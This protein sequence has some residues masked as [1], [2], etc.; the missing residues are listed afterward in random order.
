[1]TLSDDP[2]GA[3]IVV[4][5]I[6]RSPVVDSLIVSGR[7]D[8]SALYDEDGAVRW[9]GFTIAVVDEVLYLVGT[10]RRGT[11]YA[12]YEFARAIGVS[13]WHWW[14]DAPIH[15]RDHVTV[16]SDTRIS[17]WPSVRYR[18]VFINDEEELYH[19]ARQHTADDTIGPETYERVFELLLRLGGNY[20]WPAMHIG[21]FNHDPENGR[22]ANE[23]GIVVGTSH[24]DILLRSNNH[25][26]QPWADARAE[27]VEYDYSLAG[28]NRE[29]LRDY[30]RDSVEQNSDYEVT[31]TLGVR[32]VHDSGFET[33]AIDSDETLDEN[34]K[35]RARVALL[36][37]AIH[38]QRSILSEALGV[39]PDHAPQLFIPYK[40][41]LPLYDAG[42][43]VPDDVTLVW[44]NDNFG[45][46]RRFPS[47]TERA[48]AGG[49]G[50]YYHSS[51]WSNY[52][53]SYLGTSST[54]LSLMRSELTKAWAGGI[55]HLWIDNVGGLKPLEIET[56]FFLRSAWEAGRE[57]STSDIRDF[58]ARWVDDTFSGSLGTRAADIYARYYQLNNQRKYEHLSAEVFAQIGYGDEAGRRLAG[59][60]ALF[61]EANA[62]LAELPAAERDSFFEVFAIK[63][64]MAYLVNAEFVYADRSTLAHGQGKFAAADAHLAT[65]RRFGDH[66]RQLIHF[67]NRIMSE[68]RWDGIFTPEAFPPPVMPLHAAGTPA[69]RIDGAGLGVLVWGAGTTTERTIIFEPYG[70]IEKW[71][72]VFATGLPG[73]RFRVE[74]DPWIEVSPPEGIV[75]SERRLVVRLTD[76]ADALGGRSGRIRVIAPE[77]GDVIDISVTVRCES[78]RG[79]D[80]TGW[81]E[82]EGVLCIDPAQPDRLT[83]H[84]DQAW[85]I[86]PDLGR[87][88]NAALQMHAGTAAGSDD[89]IATASFDVHF[90]T[91]GAHI[92]ELHR[93]PS[94]DSTG[95]IRV[96]VSIDGGAPLTVE[97]PST[98]EHRGN[99]RSGVQDNVERLRVDLPSLTAG[100]HTINLHGIDPW[101]TISKLVIFTAEPAH[102]NLGPE[103]SAHSERGSTFGVEVDPAA[104]DLGEM[105]A[106]LRDLYRCAPDDVP[107]ADQLYADR[108]FWDGETTNRKAI[109]VAQQRLSSWPSKSS[110]PTT[111][112]LMADVGLGPLAQK[113]GVIAFEVED[114]LADTKHAWRTQADGDSSDW[115]QTQ[116]ETAARTGL[117]MHV[118]PRGLSWE[119][120]LEAPGMHFAI[121]VIGGGTF[122]VWLLLSFQ[123]DQDDSC[124]IALDGVPQL[125]E[126]QFSGG[127]LCTYGA[128]QAWIWAHLSD[129]EIDEGPHTFSIH[130]RKSG[131]RIDR[132]YLTLGDELPPVDANWHATTRGAPASA[133]PV[134][135]SRSAN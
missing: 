44:A 78:G 22:L 118:R 79:T 29:S 41:V 99:W 18:G 8:V 130:A 60:H 33:K 74:S 81:I 83:S 3:R 119:E 87:Y 92:L 13:P 61:D 59:L 20:I 72:E 96:G 104:I 69:L 40:E 4:G 39:T 77:T 116:A 94:L 108:R 23:M 66:R 93:L 131:L 65:A 91:A 71:I 32:G 123:D 2:V 5:T 31:W 82:A 90:T 62:L 51:Y 109:A 10:D 67:Y 58:V 27:P 26:F 75:D 48:R 105:D 125:V 89:A 15:P 21:A 36:Q 112:D 16:A 97:S 57:T 102:S 54:P 6:G 76:D 121:D 56:E 55:R 24:C 46:L 126:E 63:I 1:M 115:V 107:L 111:K 129:L 128:R 64:H 49:H 7:L 133:A 34:G 117:A 120:P 28:A 43:E 25:E 35:A 95:R 98:D 124:V 9:E 84:G 50:L 127:S 106:L 17:D 122:R 73:T 19:W 113:N 88:G 37:E 30:W 45:Y 134:L 114:A 132:V 101:F 70:R 68:G 100:N 86:V 12:V 11:V 135:A 103:F 110:P 52:T 14:A 38:D 42:L 85:V 53:T 80:A 47:E